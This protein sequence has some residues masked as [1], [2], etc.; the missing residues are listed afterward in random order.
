METPLMDEW[1]GVRGSVMRWEG[2][3]WPNKD[4]RLDLEAGSQ[5]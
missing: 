3:E 1:E 2:I 5:G 4:P